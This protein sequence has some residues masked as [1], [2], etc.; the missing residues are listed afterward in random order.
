[1]KRMSELCRAEVIDN[2]GDSIGNVNDVRLV[3]DGAYLDPFGNALR[4]DGLIAGSGAIAIRLGFHRHKIRG[5]WILKALAQRVE[6]Q[7]YFVPW[8]AVD[9]YDRHTVRL[10]IAKGDLQ[11]VAE[12]YD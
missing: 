7:A 11:T 10:N 4:I 8:S 6:R 9:A 3:Q 2:Q 12:A 5:P 1:M